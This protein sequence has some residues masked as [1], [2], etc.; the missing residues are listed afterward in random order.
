[1]TDPDPDLIDALAAIIRK[2]DGNHDLG[3]AALAEE[4]ICAWNADSDEFN[5]WDA[6]G[7]DEKVEHARTFY[8]TKKL[9]EAFDHWWL[10]EGSGMPPLPGE[11]HEEHTRRIARIAWHNGDYVMRP[12]QQQQQEE[13]NND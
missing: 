11:D 3:A 6:L 12:Q 5:Q 10:N 4:I 2:V 1:M 9:D 8:T 13:D 7:I